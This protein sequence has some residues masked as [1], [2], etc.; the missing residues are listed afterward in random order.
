MWLLSKITNFIFN[1]SKI[2]L[3]F[4]SRWT[5][6]RYHD[7]F[8]IFSV[9]KIQIYEKNHSFFVRILISI[10]KIVRLKKIHYEEKICISIFDDIN[11]TLKICM[12]YVSLYHSK[13]WSI[14]YSMNFD[15]RSINRK[16]LNNKNSK[17]SNTFFIVRCDRSVM[18]MRFD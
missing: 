5:K 14:V 11:M 9:R 10:I 1:K 16:N 6:I 7:H 18:I 4:L 8:K 2:R 3:Y 17:N 13:L 12:I 15:R